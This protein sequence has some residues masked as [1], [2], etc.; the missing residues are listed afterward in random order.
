MCHPTFLVHP[1][2]KSLCPGLPSLAVLGINP[3]NAGVRRQTRSSEPPKKTY[4][5]G[6]DSHFDYIIFFKGVE[7]TLEISHL[8]QATPVLDTSWNAL[9]PACPRCRVFF[10]KL[11]KVGEISPVIGVKYHPSYQKL[12][13]GHLHIGL[14]SC[15]SRA[16][17]TSNDLCFEGKK[18]FFCQLGS[19]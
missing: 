15:N 7:T 17:I 11:Y 4:R 12:C 10:E 19:R 8:Q 16:Q 14:K 2:P 9:A 6:E 18:A 5:P 3:N 1:D 13:L